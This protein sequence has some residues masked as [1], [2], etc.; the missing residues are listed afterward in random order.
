MHEKGAL[1]L[2]PIVFT[3]DV[4]HSPRHPNA[5]EAE[6]LDAWTTIRNSPT[7]RVLKVVHGH[8]SSG[9]GGTTRELVRNWLFARRARWRAIIE[10]ENYTIFDREVQLMRKELGAFPDA[11]LDKFNPGITVVWVR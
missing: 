7:L 9:K 8:G 4:A 3:I 5:V 11:D 2:S 10:G 1:P 6:L